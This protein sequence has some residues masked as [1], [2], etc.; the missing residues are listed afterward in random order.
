VADFDADIAPASLEP[1]TAEGTYTTRIRSIHELLER[2][3]MREKD[4]FP[5]KIRIGKLVKPTRGGKEKFVVIP[6]TVEEKF[7]HDQVPSPTGEDNTTGGTGKEEEG[8]ILGERP[9]RP[10]EGAGEGEAGQGEG[11]SHELE[12][13]AYDLGKILTETF[14]L[15][16]LKD[17]GKKS[18]LTRYTYDLTDKNR[19][20]GQ[21][22]DKKA[23]MRRILETNISLGNV[24]DVQDIDTTR[25]LISPKDK[26]Y[27]ILSRDIDYESQALVFF[28]RDYSGSMEGK[29][30]ELVVSQHVMIYCWLLYQFA[31]QVESRFI[32]HDNEAREVPD[33]ESYYR[34]RVAG[35]TKVASA[36]RLVNEIVEKENL[37]KDYNI[38]VF[39]GTDGD[40]WDTEGVEAIPEIK[41]MLTYTNRMGIT[42]AE[43]AYSAGR[44]SE[45]EQ[46]LINSG[47]LR[48]R[49]DVLRLDVL[50]EEAEEPRLIEGIKRLIS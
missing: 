45:V 6:T 21:L 41:Q 26:V 15:P 10:E 40:D 4:G 49:A 50:D 19:G 8:D 33:F 5:R 34:L 38:Y 17:K 28:I 46:Y 25:F 42:I 35:G 27:R 14:E 7:Y 43:H 1:P 36:Y 12:S 11:E 24:P 2:D 39:H 13:S 47:L 29:A 31:R 18:S 44:H 9:V 32:L 20:F 22:L 16:N 37:A 3:K 23:T 30:T 48:E